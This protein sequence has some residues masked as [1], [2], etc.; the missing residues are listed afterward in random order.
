MLVLTR[1][2]G[3]K[4]NIGD[5]IV[6]SVLAIHGRRVQIGVDAPVE[7]PIRREQVHSRIVK[8]G[9]TIVMANSVCD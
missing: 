4:I 5:D 6:L 9:D 8:E 3:E 7:I 1:K 2:L